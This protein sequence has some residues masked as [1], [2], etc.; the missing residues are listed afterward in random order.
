[1]AIKR[2]TGQPAIGSASYCRLAKES[3]DWCYG[4]GTFRGARPVM[5]VGAVQCNSRNRT[6][7]VKEPS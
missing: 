6:S 7:F 3:K 4:G 2:S 5:R 1:M